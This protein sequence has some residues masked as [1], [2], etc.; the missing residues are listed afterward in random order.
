MD[1]KGTKRGKICSSSINKAKKLLRMKLIVE[2]PAKR[3]QIGNND[4]NNFYRF[5]KFGTHLVFFLAFSLKRFA[6]SFSGILLPV[7]MVIEES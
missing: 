1:W 5:F 4:E 2:A 3:N 7:Q 6:V